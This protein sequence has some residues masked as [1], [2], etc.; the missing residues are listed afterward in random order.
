MPVER[1]LVAGNYHACAITAAGQ[2][3]CWG[4]DLGQG[5]VPDGSGSTTAPVPASTPLVAR[6]L[7]AGNVHTCAI[8]EAETLYCWGR[9]DWGQ[10]GNGTDAHSENPVQ[11]SGLTNVIAVSTG[12]D[13]TCAL[14]NGGTAWCWGANLEFSPVF[15]V[16]SYALLSPTAVAVPGEFVRLAAGRQMLCLIPASGA[17]VCQGRNE[18]GQLGVGGV[19]TTRTFDRVATVS[20][21][22]SIHRPLG[23]TWPV[24]G[25]SP[26]GRLYTWGGAYAIG[27][28][29]VFLYRTPT[30][31][32]TEFRF[33]K[34]S[35]GDHHACGIDARGVAYCWGVN[36]SG[37]L[38]DGTTTSRDAP[39]PVQGDLRFVDIAAGYDFTCGLTTDGEVWCWGENNRGQLGD[40]TTLA[41]TVPTPLN[42]A[43]RFRLPR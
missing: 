13:I 8:T 15:G 36:A 40:G 28:G 19:G 25:L 14:A 42:T 6:S 34:L 41:R 3:V 39:T 11:V 21:L 30:A 1:T 31:L 4:M 2:P 23:R 12:A 32:F 24:L 33:R 29:G 20:A 9:N 38:G 43:L 17:A 27:P 10:L 16:E 22:G 5:L 26:D 7:A 35:N 18:D 37:E